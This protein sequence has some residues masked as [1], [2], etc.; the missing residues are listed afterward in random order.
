[1]IRCSS[2]PHAQSSDFISIAR[3]FHFWYFLAG[4]FH[5][6]S[7]SLLSDSTYA[8]WLLF[9]Q[10]FFQLFL[11]ELFHRLLFFS[12]RLSFLFLI[13]IFHRFVYLYI[14]LSQ[15]SLIHC[16]GAYSPMF[17]PLNLLVS[18]FSRFLSYI[19]FVI[20]SSCFIGVELSL[21]SL[22]LQDSS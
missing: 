7:D 11:T 13:D 1:L 2:T 9:C 10:T 18:L 4:Q 8:C 15:E 19:L 5:R 17:K 14:Y 20:S 22:V 21:V 16:S 6:Y 12:A 3:S